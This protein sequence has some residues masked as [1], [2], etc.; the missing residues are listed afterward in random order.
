[1]VN[2]KIRHY[3][4]IKKTIENTGTNI[5]KISNK[6]IVNVFRP[7]ILGFIISLFCLL[8]VNLNI[9]SNLFSHLDNIDFIN[10][11]SSKVGINI[12]YINSVT[13]NDLRTVDFPI[14]A[15]KI[16]N[17]FFQVKLA[18]GT[19]L[20][21]NLFLMFVTAIRNSKINQVYSYS[22][23]IIDKGFLLIVL[24]INFLVVLTVN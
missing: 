5:T 6:A 8:I 17:Y 12:E 10:S 9:I 22:N 7:L 14:Y 1:M 2:E 15:E 13:L 24:F 4:E 3:F 21:F 20:G 16:E 18:M 11:I 19:F 23:H